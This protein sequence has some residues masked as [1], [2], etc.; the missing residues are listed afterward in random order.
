MNKIKISIFIIIAFVFGFI[1]VVQCQVINNKKS[2][3]ALS[4]NKTK[5]L[6]DISQREGIFSVSANNMIAV[7]SRK[8]TMT[9]PSTIRIIT[10]KGEEVLIK[11]DYG[12]IFNLKFSQDN[13]YLSYEI[14]NRDDIIG[15]RIYD[16]INKKPIEIR[17]KYN[18]GQLDFLRNSQ[19]F[20]Y[21]RKLEPEKTRKTEIVISDFQRNE[22]I[23]S[24]FGY[25]PKWSPSGDKIAITVLEP[26][27]NS[28]SWISYIWIIDVETGDKFKLEKSAGMGSSSM[29]WSPKGDIICD[30]NGF[31]LS[32][33]NTKSK[34]RIDFGEIEACNPV[35]APEGDKIA[36]IQPLYDGEKL[37]S[38]DLY[39]INSDGS[40]SVKMLDTQINYIEKVF[41]F[42]DNELIIQHYQNQNSLLS[43][44][45]IQ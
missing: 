24:N 21:M 1:V 18:C 25:F 32:M 13:K 10:D 7:T 5:I 14:S 36:Y 30:H 41:W 38:S 44:F 22:R 20:V 43:V 12:L 26:E 17:T 27:Q 45:A 29:V 15:I 34:T 42:R 35:W 39:I 4:L 6:L 31:N 11:E 9:Q 3:E 8:T 2:N 37:M 33:I 23:I 28:R 19:K 16:I 40:E